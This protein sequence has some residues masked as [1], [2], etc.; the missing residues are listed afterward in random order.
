[1]SQF[2]FNE[3]EA[4]LSNFDLKDKQ[5]DSPTITPVKLSATMRFMLW[6]VDGLAGTVFMT[7]VTLWALF[8]DD[9][10]LLT[11]ERDMDSFFVQLTLFCLCCFVVELLFASIAKAGYFAS[12]YFWL[13][14]IATCS[15]VLDIPEVFEAFTGVSE[16]D[17][18]LE[19][20]DGDAMQGDAGNA[21]AAK[22]SAT[23]T[24]AGRT[25]RAGTRAGRIVRLV[26][27][28]RILKLYKQYAKNKE[29][30]A[31]A[32]GGKGDDEH[33]TTQELEESRVGQKLSDLT[34]RRVILGVL[35][36]LFIL[37]LFDASTFDEHAT[38]MSGGFEMVVQVKPHHRMLMRFSTGARG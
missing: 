5:L 23:L 12:F 16:K 33:D 19:Y 37:P 20:N 6:C 22:E 10:R 34:T 13:D 24:R 30:V 14:C 1:V 28:V 11:T 32:R 4:S 35:L 15:L 36:M 29:K 27:L 9:L 25:S 26:R 8:G 38:L 18:T 3:A 31:D 21:D 17:S 7:M 2:V